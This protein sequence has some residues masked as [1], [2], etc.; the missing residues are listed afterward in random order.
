MSKGN[1]RIV[2][3]IGFLGIALKFPRI[4][5][6]QGLKCLV[7]DILG[8]NNKLRREWDFAVNSKGS[9]MSFLF[10]GIRDNWSEYRFYKEIRHPLLQP[11]YFSLLGLVN[12]QRA[13][14]LYDID[15]FYQFYEIIGEKVFE[16]SHHFHNPRNFSFEGGRLRIHDYGNPRTQ[17]LI[18]EHG[19]QIFRCFDPHYDNVEGK[20]RVKAKLSESER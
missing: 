12:V 10:R 17:K 2:V 13:S 5:L 8:H 1:N 3:C 9:I 18:R 20:R 16:D 11:T 4:R 7:D 6:R 14:S 19:E 15:L